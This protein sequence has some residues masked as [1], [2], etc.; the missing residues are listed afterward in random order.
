MHVPDGTHTTIGLFSFAVY[1][2]IIHTRIFGYRGPH[3]I[4]VINQP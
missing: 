2:P 3:I 1:L 4:L